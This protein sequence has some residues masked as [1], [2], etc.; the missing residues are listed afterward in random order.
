VKFSDRLIQ[1]LKDGSGSWSYNRTLD[2]VAQYSYRRGPEHPDL[3]KHC[4]EFTWNDRQ[5]ERALEQ[6]K[7]FDALYGALKDTAPANDNVK[8]GAIP[9]ITIKGEEFDKDGYTFRNLADGDA[10]GLL[11]GEFT[12]CCQH[13]GSNGESCAIHGYI[14][15]FGGFYIVEDDKTKDIGAQ[16]WAWRGKG[17]EIVFD[18]WESLKGHFNAAQCEKMCNAFAEKIKPIAQDKQITAFNVGKGGETP[19]MKQ[20]ELSTRPANPKDYEGRYYDS[21]NQYNVANFEIEVP[22]A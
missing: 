22:D 8:G 16:T 2:E 21:A 9:D 14:S 19:K 13:I 18:S 5:F 17:N 7:K 1:P 3:A 6:V 10:R 20:F 12:D 15:P 11:L 4:M